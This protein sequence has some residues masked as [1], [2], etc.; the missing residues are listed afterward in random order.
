MYFHLDGCDYHSG[1]MPS[2]AAKAAVDPRAALVYWDYY[3][4]RQEQYA[5]ALKKH[6]QFNA[7]TVFAGGIWTWIGPAPS[8]QTTIGN[9]VP[10][11]KACI[12]AG[13]KDVIATAWGDNGAETNLTTAL[14]GMQIFAEMAYTGEYDEKAIAK[15]FARCCHGNAQAFLD[16]SLLNEIPGVEYM[17]NNPANSCKFMLYQDPLIQ[18]FEGD[19][20]GYSLSSHFSCLVPLYE[21][22]A[23]ENPEY[24]LLFTFYAALARVLTRKCRWHE[25]AADMVRNGDRNGAFELASEM[26]DT[27]RS[28][29]NLRRLWRKLWESTNKP[30]GFEVL[31]IRLG[32]VAARLETA[33]DKMNAFARGEIDDIPEL[34][35]PSLPIKRQADGSIGC[36]NTQEDIATPGRI[37]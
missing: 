16:L 34:T 29:N 36:T 30:N 23:E 31:E 12:E 4:C 13:T 35:D 7:P 8:Y 15:R 19:T 32:G 6:A 20:K 17:P 24:D 11:L 37:D 1:D 28:V 5:L 25:L 26:P 3:H 14:L 21:R 9:T 18:L 10:A 2:E 33:M 27:I 22:Y